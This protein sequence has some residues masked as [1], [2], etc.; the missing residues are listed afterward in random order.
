MQ[1]N[2]DRC[3]SLLTKKTDKTQLHLGDSLIKNS[4]FEKLL[5]VIDN[6]L[7]FDQHIK[8]ETGLSDFLK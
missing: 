5:G 3:H 4:A 2:T 8:I 6:K 1:G 7:C